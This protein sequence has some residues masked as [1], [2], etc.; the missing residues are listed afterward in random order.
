MK[1]NENE[2]NMNMNHQN[3]KKI[4][5][6]EKKKRRNIVQ[7]IKKELDRNTHMKYSTK[8]NKK[9]RDNQTDIEQRKTR[10]FNIVHSAQ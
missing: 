9:E 10:F 7:K 5:L 3:I 2:M 6:E 1:W 4:E 8:R